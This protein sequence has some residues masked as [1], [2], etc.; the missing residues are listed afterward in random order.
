MLRALIL[1]M[2]LA[3]AADAAEL[4][5]KPGTYVLKGQ[6]CAD[7]A[8]AAVFQYDGREFSYPHASHCRSAILS[9]SGRRYRL[10]ETCSAL[11][12]GAPAAPVTTVSSYT[13]VS[14][15]EVRVSGENGRAPSSYRWRPAP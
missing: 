13:V 1:S 7:P 3:T 4:P 6:P 14:A 10:R 2:L 8:L 11:G 9:H 12:D 5:L 15:A